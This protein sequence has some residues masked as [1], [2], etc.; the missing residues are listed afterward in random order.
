LRNAQYFEHLH[1]KYKGK[2]QFLGIYLTEAHAADE[3]PVGPSVSFCKQPQTRAERC[4][5]AVRLKEQYEI[6]FP[7]LVDTME[8]EFDNT[9]AAW[10][11]RYY[12][13]SNG[14]LIFKAQPDLKTFGYDTSVL[15]RFLRTL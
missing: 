1:Q 10:P 11:L 3:W 6:T 8:N 12:V 13:I 7:M 2:A 9:F 15:S 4:E 14:K 5:L